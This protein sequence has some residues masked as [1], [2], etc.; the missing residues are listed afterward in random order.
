MKTETLKVVNPFYERVGKE[1]LARKNSKQNLVPVSSP[2]VNQPSNKQQEKFEPISSTDSFSYTL[3]RGSFGKSIFDEY[4]SRLKGDY[5]N[6]PALNVLNWLPDKEIVEGSNPFAAVLIN[7]ILIE[8]GLRIATHADLEK[9]ISNYSLLLQ[10]NYEDSGLILKSFKDKECTNAYFAN[11]F[12]S[13]LF[14][15]YSVNL[16][17]MIPLT[18][19]HLVKDMTSPY[20]LRF[21]LKDSA[22]IF[23]NLSILNK[24]G[25]F[26]SEDVDEQTGLPKNRNEL[27]QRHLFA[28]NSGLSRIILT[29]NLAIDSDVTYLDVSDNTGRIVIIN[30]NISEGKK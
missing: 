11:D 3:L 18:E 17:I 15:K 7:E 25:S 14:F 20:K 9:I 24:S 8:Q 21:N 4:Q 30:E 2:E 6:N 13:Q 29:T 10:G 23:D 19:L 5:N 16:P 27:G 1:Y 22:N 26:Y 12:N 28:L